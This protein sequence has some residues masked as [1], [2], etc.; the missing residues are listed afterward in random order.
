MISLYRSLFQQNKHH[1]QEVC[2][3]CKAVWDSMFDLN[4][5]FII[6][7]YVLI[8]SV[9]VMLAKMCKRRLKQSSVSHIAQ[10]LPIL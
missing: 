10:T 9:L 4:Y 1:L 8:D 2:T 6:V 3:E 7:H 5:L